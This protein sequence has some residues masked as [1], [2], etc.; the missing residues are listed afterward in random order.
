MALFFS[1]LAV[2]SFP[3]ISRSIEKS[4]EEFLQAYS[5][6]LFHCSLHKKNLRNLREKRKAKTI[7][8]LPSLPFFLLR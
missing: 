6:Y 3:Q 4:F 8:Q 2:F 1:P 7:P 5:F